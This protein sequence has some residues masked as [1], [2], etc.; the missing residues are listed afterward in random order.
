M[1]ARRLI[2]SLSAGFED[3]VS[4]VENHEAVADCAIEDLRK[5]TAGVRVQQART[6]AHV[7]RLERDLDAATQDAGRWRD[8]AAVADDDDQ[9]LEC[10]R[11]ARSAEQRRAA[12]DGQ[13]AEHRNLA[14]DL[15]GRFRELETR[16]SELQ[17]KRTSLSSREAR[18]RTLRSADRQT[19]AESLD[20]VFDRW[21]TTIITDEYRDGVSVDATDDLERTFSEQEDDADLR[22]ELATLRAERSADADPARETQA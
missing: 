18:A 1:K 21:E 2:A 8:R 4:R 9:A 10:L 6:V 16:L 19:P 14:R 17:L 15:E 20:A 7:R 11:R 5:A 13:L 3:F 12:L 22:A